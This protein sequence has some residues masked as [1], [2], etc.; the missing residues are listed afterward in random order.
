MSRYFRPSPGGTKYSISICSNSPERKMKCSTVISL[1]KLLPIW[2]MP[3]GTFMLARLQNVREL[4][5][6]RLRGFRPQ[7]DRRLGQRA[8]GRGAGVAALAHRLFDRRHHVAHRVD[9]A[10]AGAEHQ[11]ELALLGE[12]GRAAVGAHVAALAGPRAADRLAVAGEGDVGQEGLQ[13]LERGAR[14]FLVRQGDLGGRAGLGG[15]RLVG[16]ETFAA[17]LAVDQRV[18]EVRQVAA[19]FPHLRDA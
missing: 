10:E 13:L 3:K 2:A 9:R 16:P 14:P 11:V 15:G 7:V 17:D 4:H 5:E 18:G 12:V 19:R 1:R 8:L 6:H